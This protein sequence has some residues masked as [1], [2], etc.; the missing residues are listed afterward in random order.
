MAKETKK[1]QMSMFKVSSSP[2]IRDD[3]STKK[4]MY[5]VFISLVP[6]WIG[7]M[8]FY[9][10]RAFWL[11]FLAIVS[12]VV[13]EAVIQKLSKRPVEIADGSAAVTGILLAFNIPPGVSWWM[14]VFGS[15][16]AI[17][18]GKMTF[19]GLGRNPLNPA[20]VGRA[21]LMM[22]WG[23]DMTTKWLVPRGGTL[24]GIENMTD[25]FT[26]ATPLAVLKNSVAI[27]K[28]PETGS[29]MDKVPVALESLMGFKDSL[30]NLISG[31]V[32]GCI[33]ETSAIL[34]ILGAL[35]LLYKRYIGFRIPVCYIGTVALITWII[36][37][38]DGY[39]SGPWLVHIFSGGLILGAFFMA[40][41]M[42]TTPVTP[43]GRVYF[44]VGC[45]IL[46]AVIRLWGGYPEGVSY[47][48]LLMN[49]TTPLLDRWTRPRVFGEVKK[50]A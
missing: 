22:S 13:T 27:L 19:G 1:E 40:T 11:T 4:I 17:A 45:G 38:T 15:I 2:H 21:V 29:N 16:V 34:L 20:L 18:L 30:V 7:S 23:A 47:S 10:P 41:D 48:I 12:A 3:E 24:S 49:L 35:Y 31:R 5:S 36:G 14:P 28:N 32:G 46:T 9:G 8:Y 44:G 43:L 39:F 50:N 37:G 42:V 26:H 33:G 25:A 6:A